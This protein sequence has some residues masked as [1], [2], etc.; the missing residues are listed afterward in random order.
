MVYVDRNI[1]A[2][3]ISSHDFRP[4]VTVEIACG[5]A[6][7]LISSAWRNTTGIRGSRGRQV[8]GH[9]ISAEVDVCE[10]EK[11]VPIKV[12]EDPVVASVPAQG[13]RSRQ[14][15]GAI[16][17]A[18]QGPHVSRGI[19]IGDN[20]VQLAVGIYISQGTAPNVIRS[21]RVIGPERERAVAI[22]DQHVKAR[23]NATTIAVLMGD[24]DVVFFVSVHIT[25]SDL[26][27]AIISHDR[28][29]D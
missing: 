6:A 22:A 16:A 7:W 26:S 8:N 4:A 17:V 12:G 27:V 2:I 10:V 13:H 24:N 19:L 25:H 29:Q 20:H 21:D 9:L 23:G 1:V 15:K 14:L 11:A 5:H 28:S 18:Q 3:A